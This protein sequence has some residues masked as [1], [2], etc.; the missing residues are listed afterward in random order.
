MLTYADFADEFVAGERL[1]YGPPALSYKCMRLKLLMYEAL[2][3]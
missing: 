2:S 3:Y 1:V